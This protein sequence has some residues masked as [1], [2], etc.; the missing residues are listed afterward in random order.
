MA[1]RKSM[2]AALV[3]TTILGGTAYAAEQATQQPATQT[4]AIDKDVGKLSKDG[5]QAFRDLQLTRLA[6]FE[7]NPGQAKDLI[8]KTQAAFAKAKTDDAVFTKAEAELKTPADLAGQ[9]AKAKAA[10]PATT[11]AKPS[12]DQVAWVP[13]DAQLTLGDDFVATPEKASAVTEANKNLAH[14]DQKGAIEKLKLAHVDVNFTMAVLPLDKTIADVDQAATLIGQGKYYEANAVL[15][16]AQDGM[17]FDVID[18]VALPQTGK[19]AAANT[20]SP[21]ATGTTTGARTGK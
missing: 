14:G 1:Y 6:I 19:P 20:A 11:D 7:A 5:A 21:Q 10:Q 15:K 12:K 9:Q 17:R 2:A 18:A 3:L 16:T 4:R 8:G 13:V